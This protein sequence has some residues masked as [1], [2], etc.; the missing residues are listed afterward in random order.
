LLALNGESA[1]ATALIAANMGGSAGFAALNVVQQDAL[2][3]ALNMTSDELANSMLYQENLLQLGEEDK[4]R[5]IEQL[6]YLKSIGD[7]ETAQQL[8]R[9]VAAGTDIDAALKSANAQD[10]FYQNIEKIKNS[11]Q[12][13][14]EGPAMKLAR[15]LAEMAGSG[16][17]LYRTVGGI[18]I[19]L[20]G[21]KLGGLIAS[22]VTMATAASMTAAAAAATASAVTLG[23]GLIAVVAGIA[24]IM[25]GMSS[26]S[27]KAQA[28]IENKTQKKRSGGSVS[29][30]GTGDIIPALLEPKEYVIP[31]SPGKTG[32]EKYN[33]MVNS[34]K[35]TGKTGTE[36]YNEMIYSNKTKG[37]NSS[38]NQDLPAVVAAINELR[39][40]MKALA[41]RP[42]NTSIQV[43]SK[44]LILAQ[45]KFKNVQGDA[46]RIDD[47]EMS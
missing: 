21:M 31:N 22:F 5:V 1:E 9:A 20:G 13:I 30:F 19:I 24:L 7:E 17:G 46:N 39:S 35:T 34:N 44:E 29:G 25:N 42:I 33:E 37:T 8:Q 14:V 27:D 47:F 4:Q 23:I 11:L 28:D 40:D 12:Q 2:A 36:N 3:K 26:A 41:S 18:A 6:D 43:D 16:E 32:T 38:N 10:L 45:S 15:G